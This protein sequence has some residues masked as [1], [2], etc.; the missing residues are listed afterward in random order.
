MTNKKI[1]IVENNF[2]HKGDHHSGMDPKSTTDWWNLH[3]HNFAWCLQKNAMKG[4][5]QHRDY[6]DDAIKANRLGNLFKEVYKYELIGRPGMWTDC[7]FSGI[8]FE[9]KQAKFI[10]DY[11]Q[12]GEG[13][14]N[15]RDWVESFNKSGSTQV[16]VSHDT[17]NRLTKMYKE[18]SRQRNITRLKLFSEHLEFNALNRFN[19]MNAQP[20][21]KDIKMIN[22]DA[23]QVYDTAKFWQELNK[24]LLPYMVLENPKIANLKCPSVTGED[25]I[26]LHKKHCDLFSSFEY[27]IPDTWTT[28]SFLTQ[29]AQLETLRKLGE[30]VSG[31]GGIELLLAEN[32][33]QA[34]RLLQ[35]EKID[36]I[37]SDL[38]MPYS[39]GTLPPKEL[40]GANEDFG[41]IEIIKIASEKKI[42]YTVF[43][44]DIEHS[45][46]ALG[47]LQSI[48]S[49]TSEDLKT[50]E[51]A[52]EYEKKVTMNALL[53]GD[54]L[55][56]FE[57]GAT[58]DSG[59]LA[60]GH[61]SRLNPWVTALA[62]VFKTT[63]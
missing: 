27:N 34:K 61:K 45:S 12:S 57:A 10:E 21:K 42:S 32:T 55:T 14:S 37:I 43:T 5:Y 36:H 33:T 63:K 3:S 48:G 17:I 9:S 6:Y 50:A 38:G 53:G 30:R 29:W 26:N 8:N 7:I 49:I 4:F 28:W 54:S 20:S 59:R 16:E 35:L 39:Q 51:D 40:N 52:Y 46:Q 18:Q 62:K 11:I 2:P 60:L 22:M 24:D 15:C 41:G 19:I 1:L 13:Y 44:Q 56:V 25:I 23:E 31:V 47:Y 58:S